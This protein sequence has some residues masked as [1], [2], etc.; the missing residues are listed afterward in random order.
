MHMM[1]LHV[2]LHTPAC[3]RSMRVY[4]L[5]IRPYYLS[6]AMGTLQNNGLGRGQ[7]IIPQLMNAIYCWFYVELLDHD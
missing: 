1:V 3:I 6:M 2:I 4:R 5:D 7:R